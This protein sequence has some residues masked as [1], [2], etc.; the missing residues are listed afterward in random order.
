VSVHP[1]ETSRGRRFETRW[2]EG[3]RQRARRFHLKRDAEAFDHEITRRRQLGP[4]AVQQ[5]TVKGPTLNAWVSQRWA[6]EHAT[7]LEEHTRDRYASSYELHVEPWLGHLRLQEIT[8]GR[9]REWQADRVK[10]GVSAHALIKARTVLSSVLRHAAESEAIAGNPL[11]LVRPPKAPHVEDVIPLSPRI[12]EQLRMVLR[13]RDAAIVSL[14][15]YSGLR[16]GELRALRWSDI[17]QN[18]LRVARAASPSGNIKATKT[19]RGRRSVRLLAPLA[20]DLAAWRG[21]SAG[22]GHGLVFPAANGEPMTKTAWG[23]WRNRVWLPARVLVVDHGPKPYDLRHSFAS[24]LLAEGRT[25]HY[26][27]DQLGHDAALTL[28]TYGHLIDEFADSA[29]IDVEHEIRQARAAARD[30]QPAQP[31]A[32]SP[33]LGARQR[34]IIRRLA[35]ADRAGITFEDH[36]NDRRAAVTLVG[37]GLADRIREHR[38]DGREVSRFVLTARGRRAAQ[39]IGDS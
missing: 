31:L 15:A 27:A 25:V 13:P 29:N 30:W 28:S 17:R 8:V 9:I 22:G 11:A 26:V 4:L 10:A 16:P 39:Q 24:L 18:T 37:R 34:S 14:L 5:L 33:G 38:A 21:Q 36:S 35:A 1:I 20:E 32:K 19:K 7:R 23:S 6:T 12:V 2:R 3:A